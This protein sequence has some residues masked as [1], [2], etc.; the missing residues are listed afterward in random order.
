MKNYIDNIQK[1]FKTSKTKTTCRFTMHDGNISPVKF[2][3]PTIQK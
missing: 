2:I 1:I 3:V